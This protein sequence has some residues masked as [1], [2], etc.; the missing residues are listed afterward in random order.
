M[1]ANKTSTVILRLLR[2]NNILALLDQGIVSIANF[3][4]GVI[5]G[6]VS[7]PR[8]LGLYSLGFTIILILGALQNTLTTG[9]YAV[10]S[11]RLSQQKRAHYF[12]STIIH[13]LAISLLAALLVA[14]ASILLS[15]TPSTQSLSVVLLS[16]STVL[17]FISFREFLRRV[18]FANL[19]IRMPLFYDTLDSALR[20][21]ALLILIRTEKLSAATAYLAIGFAA[22]V[23]VVSWAK[24][25]RRHCIVSI[26]QVRDDLR[27]N[28]SFG[29]WWFISSTLF[30]IT[31]NV[32]PWLLT[33]FHGPTS[34][35]LWAACIGLT[36]LGNPIVI[37]MQNVV[38]PRIYRAYADGGITA[39]KK[40]TKSSSTTLGLLLAPLVTFLVFA[41]GLLL[42][43]VYGAKYSNNTATVAILSIN[44]LVHAMMFP[45][46]RALLTLGRTDLD[47]GINV[48]GVIS[49]LTVGTFLTWKFGINGAAF[50]LLFNNLLSSILQ[51]VVLRTQYHQLVPHKTRS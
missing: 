14:C 43:A 34:T 48:I 21:V 5:I 7:G 8:E 41:G 23:V 30:A 35:G 6:R 42:T 49:L 15:Y 32:Y 9:P 1:A 51:L 37:G 40:E 16:L 46:S 3:L 44:M 28:W 24:A 50:G 39:L 33:I 36:A 2:H 25:V 18:Y 17:F 45:F 20:L 12:G 47:L 4:I 31:I 11:P 19:D 27:R 26:A 22:A 38:G 29:R 10:F 13:Q